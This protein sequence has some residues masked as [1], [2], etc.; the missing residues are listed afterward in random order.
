MAFWK[1]I[2]EWLKVGGVVDVLT[3]D[4]ITSEY[5]PAQNKYVTKDLLSNCYNKVSFADRKAIDQA[6]QSFRSL[7]VAWTSGKLSVLRDLTNIV[8]DPLKYHSTLAF[9]RTA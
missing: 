9:V 6:Y 4:M 8:V 3:D 2:C 5:L 7:I 1:A